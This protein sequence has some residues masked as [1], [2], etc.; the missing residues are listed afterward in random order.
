MWYV[1]GSYA[2]D[3]IA[4]GP[5]RAPGRLVVATSNGAPTIAT[6]GRQASSCS[7]SVRNG[8]CPN[9]TMPA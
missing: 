9:D 5:N 8:R 1:P 2:V 6:S 4:R 7:G 3:R